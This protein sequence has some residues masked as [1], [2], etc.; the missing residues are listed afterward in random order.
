MVTQDVN[1]S[2]VKADVLVDKGRIAAVG[3]VRE[4]ADEIVEAAGDILMPGLINTHGHV[5]M[6]IMKGV[7]DDVPFPVFLDKV[8][9]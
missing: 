6:S 8:F 9:A 1:R 2:I 5:A 3:D 4:E 7:A